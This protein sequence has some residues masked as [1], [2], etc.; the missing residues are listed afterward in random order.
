[1]TKRPAILLALFASGC[2]AGVPIELRLDELTVELSIDDSIA[3]IERALAAAGQLPPGTT[4]MVVVRV[5][6][7]RMVW[8][9]ALLP[10]LKGLAQIF[11]AAFFGE[12]MATLTERFSILPSA[13]RK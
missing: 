7:V 1:M 13:S 5:P 8:M 11:Y 3:E 12:S 9:I 10:M 4:R 2:G 6:L